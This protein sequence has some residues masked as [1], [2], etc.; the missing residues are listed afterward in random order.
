MNS[1]PPQRILVIKL[2][3][4]GDF[5]LAMGAFQAIRAHHDT[6]RITLLTTKAYAGMARASGCFDDVW[7]DDR[8][9]LFH[10]GR[11]LGLAARLWKGHFER[12]YDLQRSQ[13]TGWYFHLFGPR[14]PE[15]IGIVAGCSHRYRDPPEP[16]HIADRL[17][18]MLALA[19]IDRTPPPDLSFLT[20]DTAHFALQRPYA[21]LVR[22]SVV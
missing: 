21:L 2:S 19:G 7:I 12:V 14:K 16:T 17:A 4:L 20:A 13:R 22:K 9:S 5:L 6:A 15:W 10:P 18:G 1:A 3:A 11:W 8:P